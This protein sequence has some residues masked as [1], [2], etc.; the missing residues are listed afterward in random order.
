LCIHPNMEGIESKMRIVEDATFGELVDRAA[1]ITVVDF[2]AAWCPPCRVIK[3]ILDELAGES[4]GK[5]GFFA[6]DVDDNPESASRFGVRSLPTVLFFQD[7]VLK[8][9]LVGALP[10]A[11]FEQRITALTKAAE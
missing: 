11:A 3:P 4:A 2:G 5:A 9:R 6:L 8:D 7:G 1:G 10:K